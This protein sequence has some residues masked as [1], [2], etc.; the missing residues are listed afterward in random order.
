MTTI[1]DAIGR[2]EDAVV[3]RP[4]FGSAT[5]RSRAT[6]GNDLRCVSVEG[7]WTIDTDLPFA[8][9]G[10]ASAPTPT[11]LLRAALGACMAMTYRIRA[12][13]A[14]L[15]PFGVSVDVEADSQ[16]VGMLL[17]AAATPPG[18][19]AI[20]YDVDV[21][22]DAP[23]SDVRRVLDEGDRLSP[24]LDVIRRP[25]AVSRTTTIRAVGG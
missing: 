8:F 7:D 14:G 5:S 21:E 1:A 4:G 9:G 12:E 3:R 13:R 24:V 10:S 6:L 11:M 20:R 17:T 25:T 2:L 22:C 15:G 19:T 23:H 18:F 16:L